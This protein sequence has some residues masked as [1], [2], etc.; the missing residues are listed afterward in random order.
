MFDAGVNTVISIDAEG[1]VIRFYAD[2]M[3][4]RQLQLE[5]NYKGRPF[6]ED[7]CQKLDQALKSYQQKSRA[8]AAPKV[9]I[10]LPDH[11]FLMDTVNVP[12]I[13]KK[14]MENAVEVG[15]GAI[16]KN[17]RD[18][19]YRWFPLSQTKQF[20][21]F[22]VVGVRK[23]VLDKL[24]DLCNANQVSLQIVSFAANAM[25][26]GAMA[27]NAK[28]RNG[29][30][31]VLDVQEN[32]CRFAFVNKGRV[33]GAYHLPFGD[34]VLSD[35]KLISEDLLFDHS[36]AELLVRT[37]RDKAKVKSA[38]G[39]SGESVGTLDGEE[40]L[41]AGGR[42][43]AKRATKPRLREMPTEPQGF[44]YENFR[45]ILKWTLNLLQ[46][47]PTIL[48]QGDVDTVY[49]N[50]APEYNFLFDKINEEAKEN[51]VTFVPV[52]TGNRQAAAEKDLREL[53]MFGG[54][55]MKQF[56]KYNNF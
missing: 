31:L 26:C 19:H 24:Q 16:Y 33:V 8:M 34:T 20:A 15:I 43:A 7:F 4:R 28:L 54:F 52:F 13:G 32:A 39:L 10:V 56:G 53:E 18:L 46:S 44:I 6:G 30:G 48:A 41:A 35:A 3:N 42:K 9:A 25:A 47:N 22:G 36:S 21:T 23:D 51:G 1:E 29:T 40:V 49:M 45:I 38:A 17:K 11:L 2:N 27:Y 55:Q 50:I 5:V 14:A 37:A 12:T